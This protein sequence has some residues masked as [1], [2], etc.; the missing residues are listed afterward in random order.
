MSQMDDL[1]HSKQASDLLRNSDKLNKLRNSPETQ[2]IFSMLQS[3]TGG[4]LEAVAQQAASG[5]TSQL[6]DAIHS[7]MK[8]PEG[9]KLLT[10]LKDQFQ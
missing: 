1:L 5:N 8:N 6:V 10:K 2:Q 3:R 4:N 9:A 7:L